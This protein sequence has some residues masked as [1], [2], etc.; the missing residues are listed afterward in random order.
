MTRVTRLTNRFVD[1]A[2]MEFLHPYT[3]WQNRLTIL[4]LERELKQRGTL[5]W[6]MGF[7]HFEDDNETIVFLNF[8]RYYRK[9]LRLRIT[10][11]RQRFGRFIQ[12][13]GNRIA[14]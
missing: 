8:P 11:L 3:V 4:M 6:Y 13:I 10:Q 14:Q 7:S 1:D 9:S 5:E 2:L 12:N